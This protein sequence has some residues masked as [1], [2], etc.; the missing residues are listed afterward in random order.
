MD[1][2]SVSRPGEHSMESRVRENLMHGLER[3]NTTCL[4][5]GKLG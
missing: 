5:L 1:V 3:G 2:K 4:A